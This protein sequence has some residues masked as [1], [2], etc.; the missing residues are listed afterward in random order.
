MWLLGYVVS[1]LVW[2]VVFSI[3]AAG[4][5]YVYPW[6]GTFLEDGA[7]WSDTF[8]I[9]FGLVYM[10]SGLLVLIVLGWIIQEIND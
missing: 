8:A 6:L 5:S 10:F 7:F 3:Y 2:L 9:G 1:Y 4:F